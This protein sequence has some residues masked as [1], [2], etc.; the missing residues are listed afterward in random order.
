MECKIRGE[1]KSIN[2]TVANSI[3]ERPIVMTDKQWKRVMLLIIA[4]TVHNIPE[5][6]A[7]GVGFAAVGS[8]AKSTFERAR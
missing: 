1:K 2:G 4:I 8:S 7:V 5:G 6:M 3:M